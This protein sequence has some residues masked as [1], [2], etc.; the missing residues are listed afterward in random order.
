MPDRKGYHLKKRNGV[1]HVW[2]RH[3][4][5]GFEHKK[6]YSRST[7]LSAKPGVKWLEDFVTEQARSID[8]KSAAKPTRS[9]KPSR[10]VTSM[11]PAD[12]WPFVERVLDGLHLTD[13]Q[14][15]RVGTC[16]VCTALE[17]GGVD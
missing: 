13:A 5:P 17:A 12:F 6:L 16:L 9:R 1:W 2:F 11:P 3:K 10:K 8:R 7:G 15:L 14:R 4:P